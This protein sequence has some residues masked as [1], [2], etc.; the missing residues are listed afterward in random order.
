MERER[1]QN[2]SLADGEPS[3][4]A[5]CCPAPDLVAIAK[6]FGAQN[7]A[8]RKPVVGVRHGVWGCSTRQPPVFQQRRV[9]E[10]GGGA[11]PCGYMPPRRRSRTHSRAAQSL[12]T[13]ACGGGA[14]A[15][16]GI[17]LQRL[18]R[19]AAEAA[20]ASAAARAAPPPRRKV[21]Q[22][23]SPS[24]RRLIGAAGHGGVLQPSRSH[25]RGDQAAPPQ[26]TAA[27]SVSRLRLSVALSFGEGSD[28]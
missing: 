12:K 21:V 26:P 6:I 15:M 19:T 13:R 11:A 23:P 5:A 25:R 3:R 1:Q 7:E 4:P 8:A 2:D 24:A 9:S 22:G 17:M 28:E 16:G 10:R 20:A 14:T 18:G 27:R